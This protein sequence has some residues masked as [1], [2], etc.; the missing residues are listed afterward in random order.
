MELTELNLNE[1]QLKGVQTIIDNESKKVKTEYDK[2]YKT[3]EDYE[4]LNTSY[5]ELDGKYTSLTDEI[6]KLREYKSKSEEK[7]R[8]DNIK[9]MAED[10]G[11]NGELIEYLNI[12][13]KSDEELQNY[14]K[15]VAEII[16]KQQKDFVPQHQYN[17]IKNE[18]S[19][20]DF[21]KMS[22]LEKNE[23][24]K[25]DRDLYNLLNK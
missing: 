14:I 11:L 9:K 3:N 2:K 6:L 24:Y 13:D 1:E 17:N 15:G 16:S 7:I 12:K 25:K 18:I 4:K 5:K 10:N 21:K 8:E 22:F 20:E 23:L 19:K